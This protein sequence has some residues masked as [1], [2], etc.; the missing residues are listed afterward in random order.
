VCSSD[1]NIEPWRPCTFV[2][3]HELEFSTKDDTFRAIELDMFV[4]KNFLVTWHEAPLPPIT[5]TIERC[6]KSSPRGADRMLHTIL[7]FLVV[8][9]Q[10]AVGALTDRIAALQD[11]VFTDPSHRTLNKILALKKQVTQLH[12]IITPQRELI[13]RLAR[14]EFK[15]IRPQLLPYFRDVH[16]ALERIS[17][18]ADSQADQ[19]TNT[20]HVYLSHSSNQINEVVKV[21]T[22]LNA[23]SLPAL[24]IAS[25]Y[26][27]NFQTPWPGFEWRYGFAFSIALMVGTTWGLLY[28][29]RRKKWF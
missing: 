15:I 16:D 18:A 13:T 4:G 12:Q 5:Q 9:Y 2:V 23:V 8:G 19:L 17:N 3:V 26:G 22:I 28:W 1:L 11:R 14:G 27:M 6:L 20:L 24:V 10:P 25:I 7:D 29:L 21:L